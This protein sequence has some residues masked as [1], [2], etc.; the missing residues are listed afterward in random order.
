MAMTEAGTTMTETG[1]GEEGGFTAMM[2]EILI[3]PTCMWETYT[4]R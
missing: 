2:M 1:T 4:R 3:Q